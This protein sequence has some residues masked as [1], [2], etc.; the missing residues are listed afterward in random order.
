MGKIL[1]IFIILLLFCSVSVG[2]LIPRYLNIPPYGR[3]D[4]QTYSRQY[5]DGSACQCDMCLSIY[6]YQNT[7]FAQQN[8]PQIKASEELPLNVGQEATPMELVNAGI[9]VAR[10]KSSD[11][12]CDIGAGDARWVIAAVKSSG[13]TGIGVEYDKRLVK[14]ARKN[15]ED[16]GLSGKITIIEGDARK[17]DYSKITVISVHLYD[18]LLNELKNLG[19]FNYAQTIIAPYHDIQGLDMKQVDGIWIYNRPTKANARI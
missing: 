7:Y 14:L 10:L 8:Q 17:Y 1:R 4:L 18:D 3:I 19:A 12:F 9:K 5:R 6:P 2:D 13:C 11:T 16:A 15:V